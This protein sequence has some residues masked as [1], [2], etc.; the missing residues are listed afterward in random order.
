LFF[1]SVAREKGGIL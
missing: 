1:L